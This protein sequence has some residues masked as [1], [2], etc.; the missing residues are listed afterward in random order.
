MPGL[1]T[2][3]KTKGNA[4]KLADAVGVTIEEVPIGKGVAQHF[5]DLNHD[6]ETQDITYENTQARYRTMLLMNKANQIGGIVLGTGDL[7]EIALGWC[8]FS[9]DHLSHYN[10][11]AGVPKTLVKNLVMHFAKTK[12]TATLSK[13]L[14]DIVETPISPELKK[15]KAG[16]I[17]QKTEDVIGPY[18]LHDFFL[19]YF[20]RWGTNPAKILWLAEKAFAGNYT[21]S[22]IQKWLIV[23]INRFFRNQWKRSVMPDGPKVGSVAL[24]PRGDWRMP[25]DAEVVAWI[26][27]LKSN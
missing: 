4:W 24:S 9:G 1:G 20:V 3:E 12:S 21:R 16:E 25:S 18:I 13:V 5:K 7:S 2:T 26:S 22:D 27:D 8:T 15:D 19:Y 17:S 23:F 10:I 11:N 6:G 14:V